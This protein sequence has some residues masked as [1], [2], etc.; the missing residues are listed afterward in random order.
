MK[1]E[2]MEGEGG[3]KEVYLIYGLSQAVVSPPLEN[4]QPTQE[5]QS[6]SHPL[7]DRT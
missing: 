6:M 3:R 2:G 4:K 7:S 5:P 1:P